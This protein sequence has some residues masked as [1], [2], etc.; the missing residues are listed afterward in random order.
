MGLSYL[1]CKCM[2]CCCAQREWEDL[3]PLTD[4]R[5][6][7]PCGLSLWLHGFF[8]FFIVCYIG[9]APVTLDSWPEP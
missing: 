8:G 7:D 5:D 4:G 1:H 2:H 6:S 9:L 3:M